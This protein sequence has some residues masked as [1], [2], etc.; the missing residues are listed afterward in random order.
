[1]FKDT[2]T[3]KL[4]PGPGML[5][6][7]TDPYKMPDGTTYTPKTNELFALHSTNWSNMQLFAQKT[8]GIP[9][10]GK[11][12]TDKFG[13]FADS[14][15]VEECVRIFGEIHDLGQQ[16]G[17]PET[18]IAKITEFA[19]SATPPKELYGHCVWLA[20]KINTTAGNIFSYYNSAFDS[21]NNYEAL[22]KTAAERKSNLAI[23]LLG[24]KLFDYTPADLSS[25]IKSLNQQ[26][27][28]PA[29]ASVFTS[30]SINL[31]NVRI[32]EG[33]E[34]AND[35][36]VQ[37]T[38]TQDWYYLYQTSPGTLS[39]YDGYGINA[40]AQQMKIRCLDLE[41]LLG[42]FFDNLNKTLNGETDSLKWYLD[43]KDNV[44]S[45]AGKDVSEDEKSMK[46]LREQI[47][48]LNDMYIGF[49]V[50]ASCSPLF[51]LIPIIGIPMA[52]ADATAF[53]IEAEKVRKARNAAEAQ[54]KSVEAD[55]LKKISLRDK[56]NELNG[57]AQNLNTW[58]NNFLGDLKNVTLSWTKMTDNLQNIVAQTDE[59]DMENMALFM[60]KIHLTNAKKDW[61]DIGTAAENFM[62]NGFLKFET[63]PSSFGSPQ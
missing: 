27:L 52:I 48:K 6:A 43:Q 49:T 31:G 50:A 45:E 59:K 30:N 58:G 9:A 22:G 14:S 8:A 26:N 25:D 34:K 7:N 56:I 20:A 53:G 21:S 63:Q 54:L 11:E 10:D 36:W 41:G 16:Y 32:S 1:M 37:D 38:D 19:G 2:G 39:I 15:Q 18:L 3:S 35:W 28:P 57:N 51:L 5:K 17:S 12:F 23:F 47:K 40:A 24:T 33:G 62:D 42:P 55:K 4:S 44:Y 61:Q 13:T 29:L 60:E 46:D